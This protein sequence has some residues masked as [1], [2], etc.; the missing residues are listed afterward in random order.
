[1]AETIPSFWL[2]DTHILSQT[3]INI[4]TPKQY[5]EHFTNKYILDCHPTPP[6]STSMIDLLKDKYQKGTKRIPK[7]SAVPVQI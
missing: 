2:T 1:M 5:M 6:L 4:F 3:Y 7:E